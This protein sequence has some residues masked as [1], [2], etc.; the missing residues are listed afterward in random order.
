MAGFPFPSIV[1]IPWLLHQHQGLVGHQRRFF[2]RQCSGGS[3]YSGC[4]TCISSVSGGSKRIAKVPLHCLYH[5]A[6]MFS[7]WTTLGSKVLDI[8]GDTDSKIQVPLS[9]K[10]EKASNSEKQNGKTG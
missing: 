9:E 7:K 1:S 5:P 2:P 4:L 6:S 3:Q 8:L 10:E